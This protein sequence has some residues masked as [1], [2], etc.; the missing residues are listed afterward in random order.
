MKERLN[1]LNSV[2]AHSLGHGCLNT[3]GL[4]PRSVTLSGVPTYF[5][6]CVVGCVKV[7]SLEFVKMFLFSLDLFAKV[8][9]LVS[10]A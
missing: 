9:C 7:K 6:T 2:A 4:L 3:D 1:A 5:R 10:V 8:K